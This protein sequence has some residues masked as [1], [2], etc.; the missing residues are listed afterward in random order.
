MTFRTAKKQLR[1]YGIILKYFIDT[2]EYG[3]NYDGGNDSTAY[4]TTDI[5]DAV[6]TG[7]KMAEYCLSHI[8][9]VN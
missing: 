3:V 8:H 6:N 2:E 5:T 9:W 1:R 4:Y 7:L